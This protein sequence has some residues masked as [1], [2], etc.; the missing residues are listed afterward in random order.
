ML[1][2]L[3]YSIMLKLCSIRKAVAILQKFS[4]SFLLSYL[5]HKTMSI[6]HFYLFI[7]QIATVQLVSS[8][9]IYHST[10]KTVV[11]L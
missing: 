10:V 9:T 6:T 1:Q 3:T 4:I 5:N 8:P 2:N 7:F 11:L